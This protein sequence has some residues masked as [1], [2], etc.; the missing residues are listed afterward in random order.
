[1]PLFTIQ[2]QKREDVVHHDKLVPCLSSQIPLWI[3][4]KRHELFDLDDTLG[5][6]DAST[7]STPHQAESSNST[8]PG[9]LEGS[10][11]LDSPDTQ[12]GSALGP[13]DSFPCGICHQEVLDEDD[14]IM[15]DG[16]CSTWF[17]LDCTDLSRENF[18]RLSEC[19]SSPWICHGC[20]HQNSLSSLSSDDLPNLFALPDTE[21]VKRHQQTSKPP[22]Y[23]R[24]YTS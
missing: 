10:S 6:E 17:H 5:C 24:D 21:P 18:Q 11:D 8:P 20:L 1:M 22:A 12:P 15:C 19:T 3:R 2:G 9:N 13:S 7:V 23:L 14:A 16:D 4:K